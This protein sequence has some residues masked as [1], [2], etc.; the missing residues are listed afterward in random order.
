MSAQRR[1]KRF[2]KLASGEPFSIGTRSYYKVSFCTMVRG[3]DCAVNARHVF[4]APWT[5]VRTF[6]L[7]KKPQPTELEK[8]MNKESKRFGKLIAK[9]IASTPSSFAAFVESRPFPTGITGATVRPLNVGESLSRETMVDRLVINP[10]L[11]SLN[12]PNQTG[13]SA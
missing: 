8:L 1:W 11:E 12:H 7:V 3:A 10:P 4:I 6:E 13:P 2:C 9:E 5:K